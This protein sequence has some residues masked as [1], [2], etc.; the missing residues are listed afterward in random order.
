[1][2]SSNK[3]FKQILFTRLFALTLCCFSGN[4]IYAGIFVWTDENG[5]KV[6]SDSPDNNKQAEAV[7][8]APITILGFPELRDTGSD[9]SQADTNIDQPIDYK[10]IS[11]SNPQ[12]DS[13]IRDNS[14]T[15]DVRI[16]TDPALAKGYSIEL[17]LDKASTGAPRQSSSFVLSNVDRGSHSVFAKLYDPQGKLLLTS[18]PITFHMHRVVVKQ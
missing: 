6:Y 16:V 3:V 18:Q 11:I 13:T 12:H 17:F 5:N 8:L 2:S 15:V 9:T 7:E 4:L 14:G 10:S 1:M